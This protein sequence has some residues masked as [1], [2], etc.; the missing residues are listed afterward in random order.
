MA[1][2][3]YVD[4]SGAGAEAAQTEQISADVE[5]DIRKRIRSLKSHQYLDVAW[6]KMAN[7]LKEIA[8]GAAA[9]CAAHRMPLLLT[10]V[11]HTAPAASRFCRDE[12][13]R[14]R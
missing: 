6:M 11:S 13:Q 4:G 9:C 1:E 14:G 2:R 3:K 12:K 5:S 10:H 7:T 8:Q